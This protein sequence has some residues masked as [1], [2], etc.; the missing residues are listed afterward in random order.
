MAVAPI[1]IMP[2]PALEFPVETAAAPATQHTMKRNVQ[3]TYKT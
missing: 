2:S 1:P 3:T